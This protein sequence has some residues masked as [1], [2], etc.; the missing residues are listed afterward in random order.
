MHTHSSAQ[1]PSATPAGGQAAAVHHVKTAAAAIRKPPA[2]APR[3]PLGH[4]P[5]ASTGSLSLA[6]NTS[7][8]TLADDPFAY[9]STS[10]NSSNSPSP[11]KKSSVLTPLYLPNRALSSVIVPSTPRSLR[12][13]HSHRLAS[14]LTT[15]PKTRTTKRA[16]PTPAVLSMPS[17]EPIAMLS[18]P[19]QHQHQQ[20]PSLSPHHSRRSS[21]TPSPNHERNSRPSLAPLSRPGSPEVHREGGRAASRSERLLRDTLRR[22]ERA[23]SQS[24]VRSRAGSDASMD[25]PRTNSIG[26]V[27]A[28]IAAPAPSQGHAPYMSVPPSPKF[29]RSHTS[30]TLATPPTHAHAHHNQHPHHQLHLH[31]QTPSRPHLAHSPAT[32]PPGA[33]PTGVGLGISPT[34]AG[35]MARRTHS[36]T[37]PRELNFGPWLNGMTALHAGPAQGHVGCTCVSAGGPTRATRASR[38]DSRQS[39]GSLPHS[40]Q[41]SSADMVS[42]FLFIVARV[43]TD[44]GVWC[45]DDK[46][47]SLRR[48]A[49]H[50]TTDA[51]TYSTAA[52]PWITGPAAEARDRSFEGLEGVKCRSAIESQRLWIIGIRCI[53]A[54]RAFAHVSYAYHLPSGAGSRS[55]VRDG[56]ISSPDAEVRRTTSRTPVRGEDGVRRLW[57]GRWAGCA[58]VVG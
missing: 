10:T 16:L 7:G 13:V 29:T 31:T 49:P 9:P 34:L 3:R 4:R 42:G 36:P 38:R 26:E 15:P 24:R 45:L 6:S 19:T 40:R 12:S 8:T 11:K 56:S 47:E 35:P 44:P 41:N 27:S 33:L 30:Q 32:S 23:R 22:D 53:I 52:A 39:I 25:F 5:T 1:S 54:Q 48:S 17:T 37:V 28:Y 50:A 2:F 14:A 43:Y 51:T 55:A 18:P 58:G 20:R 46:P 21:I 57:R